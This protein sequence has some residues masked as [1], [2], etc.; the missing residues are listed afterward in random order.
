MYT[1]SAS[2]NRIGRNGDE[3]SLSHWTPTGAIPW[4]VEEEDLDSAKAFDPVV[5]TKLLAKLSCDGVCVS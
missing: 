2:R 3:L 1:H 5:H 4:N